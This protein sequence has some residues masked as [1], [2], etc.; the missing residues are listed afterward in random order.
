MEISGGGVS[1]TP[2]SLR[3]SDLPRRGGE[4][5]DFLIFDRGFEWPRR[6]LLRPCRH[7]RIPLHYEFPGVRKLTPV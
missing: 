7:V 3:K 4:M 2:G 6:H 5:E 1:G